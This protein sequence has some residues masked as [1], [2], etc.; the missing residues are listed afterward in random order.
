MGYIN[1]VHNAEG[2]K[3]I[4]GFGNTFVCN[5]NIDE[6]K[7]INF[8]DGWNNDT[9]LS[10]KVIFQNGHNC[11]DDSTNMTLNDI[12]VVVNK[13]GVLTPLPIHTF[14]ESGT[15]VYKSLQPNTVLEMYYTS[16]YDGADTPAFVIIGN[17]IVLSDTDYT[18]YADGQKG[19]QK[20]IADQSEL[21]DYET[22]TYTSG[23]AQTM[24]YDGTINFTCVF[25]Y[26][27]SVWGDVAI[28][29]N[30]TDIAR[31]TS[32]SDNT[33]QN[34]SAEVKKG[35]VVTVTTGGSI[36]YNYARWYKK[37]DY[38]MR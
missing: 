29:I 18:I 22:F 35:D 27:G 23:V 28:N 4:S 10:F 26:A 25:I 30:G 19:G 38:S 5:N 14:D 36:L 33:V 32:V 31:T 6:D 3:L 2:Y 1:N 9:N 17:P 11:V 16:N 12:A 21:S 7:T 15:P 24:A 34:I 20:Y 13:Y 37:R 8:P